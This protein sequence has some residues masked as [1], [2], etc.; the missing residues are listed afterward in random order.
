[1]GSE[2]IAHNTLPKLDADDPLPRMPM[3]A[4]P[5]FF[6]AYNMR[7]LF[8]VYFMFV[9]SMVVELVAHAPMVLFFGS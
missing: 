2:S 9:F 6:S 8:F 3:C 7:S 4:P 1:M 5:S